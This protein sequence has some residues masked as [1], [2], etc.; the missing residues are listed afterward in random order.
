MMEW[1]IIIIEPPNRCPEGN[2]PSSTS[3]FAAPKSLEMLGRHL[4]SVIADGPLSTLRMAFS[5]FK[6]SLVVGLLGK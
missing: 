3:I 4:Q 1:L 5:L 6:I 2:Q